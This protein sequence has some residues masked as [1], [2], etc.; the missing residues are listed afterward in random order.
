MAALLPLNR[1]SRLASGVVGTDLTGRR[2]TA[3]L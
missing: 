1:A 2:E 3:E